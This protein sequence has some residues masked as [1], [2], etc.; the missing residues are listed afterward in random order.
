MSELIVQMYYLYH[1]EFVIQP[2]NLF[3][4]LVLITWICIAIAILLNKYLPLLQNFGLFMVLVGGFITIVT[5]AAM[6]KQHATRS[7]VW[8][9]WDNATGWSGGVAFLTGCLNG[10][11][12]IGTPDAVT[13]MA[14]ELPNPKRDLPKAVFAQI[15]LGALSEFLC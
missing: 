4:V 2:W 12:T 7:F 10:A 9:D 11:F 15:G 6:P 8:T 13:H 3:V 14:E 1:P 5:V